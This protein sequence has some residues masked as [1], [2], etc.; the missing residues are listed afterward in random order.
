MTDVKLTNTADG[1]DVELVNG[2]LALDEGLATAVYISLFG[3]NDDDSGLD[4]D[5]PREWWGNKSE[6]DPARKLRSETQ[7]LLRSLPAIPANLQRVKQA[8]E[9][10]LSWLGEQELV[11]GI[12][13]LASIPAVDR[14]RLDID[15]YVTQGTKIRL[16]F[17]EDWN[18]AQ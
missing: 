2:T 6:V 3:G 8:V 18:Q 9:R 12:V 13:V 14:L 1:G 11:T 15:V 10:D 4:A 16:S 7:F 17:A 5:I